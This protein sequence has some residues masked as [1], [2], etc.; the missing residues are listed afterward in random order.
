MDT[1]PLAVEEATAPRVPGFDPVRMLG[2]GSQGQVWLLSP[3]DGAAPV[4][5]KILGTAA[6]ASPGQLHGDS[7]GHNEGSITQEWRVLSQFRHDHLLPMHRLVRSENGCPVLLMEFAPGGSLSG[8]V[9]SRGPLSIGETVTVL[10][11]LGQ[12]LAYLHARGAVHGDISPGNILFTAAGKPMLA[13]CG[14]ARL[15]GQRRGKLAGTPGF[16]CPTDQH[17]DAAADVYALAS[18][19]WFALTGRPAPTTSNRMPLGSYVKDVPGELLAALE[20]GLQ[21]NPLQR[22]TAAAL[23]QAVFRSARAEAVALG[24]SVHPSVLPELPTRRDVRVRGTRSGRQR[25]RV[26]RRRGVQRE[27]R[28]PARAA[29]RAVRAVQRGGRGLVRRGRPSHLDK[30]WDGTGPQRNARNTWF[31]IAWGALVLLLATLII[32]GSVFG[33]FWPSGA[34]EEPDAQATGSPP[35]PVSP[36]T[37]IQ[38]WGGALPAEVQE[39]LA[40]EDPVAAVPALAWTRSYAL[41]TVNGDLLAKVN[42]AESSAARADQNI[43]LTLR[44]RGHSLTGLETIVSDPKRSDAAT[45]P[46]TATVVA[47]V[48]TSAFAEQDAGGTVVHKH[49]ARDAQMLALVLTKVEGRWVVSQVQT[50]P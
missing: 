1:F 16:Y 12:V 23:A 45:T 3:H 20:A 13:D 33:M 4:A 31:A 24:T 46:D 6:E 50:P 7:E 30:M 17:R 42:A 47:R 8:I 29:A 43:L 34:N 9:H 11:P 26:A 25:L 2:K 36:G 40:A 28:G 22:P 21:E 49:A 5:A 48:A 14:L 10:T 19:G 38:G 37:D 15:V 27:R 41:S 35:S 18:V 44:S 32:A 39:G